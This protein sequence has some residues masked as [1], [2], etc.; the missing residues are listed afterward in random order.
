MGHSVGEYVAAC[1][2]GVFSLEEGLKLIA[3]RGKL[4]Q[5]LPS[6][7]EMVSAMASVEKV[8]SIIA[9]Y[10]DKVA[11]AAINSPQSTVI[12]GASKDIKTIVEALTKQ[13]IK[14][15][16]LQ[17]SH[18]F[19]SP[20]MTP[21]LKEF[22]QLANSITYN[23]PQIPIIS[24]V[25]GNLAAE[26]INTAQYWVNHI[27]QPVQFAKS[28]ETLHELEYEIF[29]EI[30]PK[31]I[32]LG[33]GRECLPESTGFRE[34]Q[35]NGLWLASV[36]PAMN[37][38]QQLLTSLGELYE[39]GI[40]ID[41]AG[42]HRDYPG[43]KV[44]L[45]NYPFQRER[46][47]IESTATPDRPNENSSPENSQTPITNLLNRGNTE[48]LM[49]LL[50]KAGNFSEEQKKL[51]PEILAALVKEHQQHLVPKE[52]QEWCYELV[53]QQQE[54]IQEIAPKDSQNSPET[55]LLFADKQGIAQ[56]LKEVFKNCILV[57]PGEGYQQRSAQ[58]FTI[59]PSNSQDFDRLLQSNQIP[60]KGI[61]YLW[62]L[63]A[64]EAKD[65]TGAELE[66]ASQIGCGGVLFL[67]QSIAKQ[68]YS[69]SP[70][71]WLVTKGAQPVG[72]TSKLTGVA[73][74]TLW[75]LGRV[76]NN[77]HPE[78]NCR[79]VDLDPEN[80][81]N[82]A[83]SLGAE[84]SSDRAKNSENQIAF[85]N[86]KRYVNRIIK[87]QKIVKQSLNIKADATYLITGGM[88]GIGLSVAQSLVEQGAKHLV[89][90]GR[91]LPKERAKATINQL[92]EMGTQVIAIQA[93][94]SIE[95]EVASL[96]N[97]I[98]TIMPPLKGIIHA[99]GVVDNRR[100]LEHQW[101]LFAKVFAPKVSGTW[102][103]HRLTQ[104]LAL[105]FFV[106]F[107]S[108]SC[109]LGSAG[110]ANYAAAN[111]FLDGMAHYRSSLNLPG[112]SIN[113]GAWSDV[114]MIEKVDR[115][116]VER[117]QTMGISLIAPQQGKAMLKQLLTQTSRQVTVLPIN[118]SVFV[119][120]STN[121]SPFFANFTSAKPI[122]K[123]EFLAQLEATKV[124]RRY[125]L[126][127]DHVTEQVGQVLGRKLSTA[128][129]EQGF[130]E[131]GMDSLMAVELRNRL[132]K[133]LA[134]SLPATLSFD[135]PNVKVLA[136][137]LAKDYLSIDKPSDTAYATLRERTNQDISQSNSDL[138]TDLDELSESEIE[139][140]L[141]EEL[142]LIDEGKKQ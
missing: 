60:I 95:A 121:L 102:N 114:G 99:A 14:T 117:L 90:V 104:D 75:G 134:C 130:F 35:P 7:G 24:N 78:L 1:V 12:S 94:I 93:D 83:Q 105:D 112:L 9:D 57:F 101:E 126:V 21:M 52:N 3:H 28:M 118:W 103:L 66:I 17:V 44:I 48:E 23:Q 119:K 88:G 133:S 53:W 131:L 69:Q 92:E 123:S 6:G 76:I 132:Q 58:E 70:S 25:T 79:L 122:Q 140:L 61:V 29:V 34:R 87:Q 11:I 74:S 37:E 18:A 45:P 136:D 97:Q 106:L 98:N 84:I 54:R 116:E 128:E 96:L 142:A 125:Q 111:A 71:L 39:A 137:Y 67:I 80:D 62:S 113:W 10:G 135:Y 81:R 109:I 2:A 86:G 68:G 42:V 108:I 50:Q 139:Q 43:N 91:S 26:N 4:M 8:K 15:K 33:M 77:E 72:E 36:R 59:N 30:G 65:L 100:I 16:Q 31:P 63:D 38:W 82:N 47:W 40:T 124:D 32:L 27:I 115:R 55:W 41:W 120:Q 73:Q 46:Y 107:S 51:L 56:E 110:T 5:Q 89:L 49:E 85:R 22:E 64:V 13:G 19:H 127:I 141:A 138:L 129:L 20:L